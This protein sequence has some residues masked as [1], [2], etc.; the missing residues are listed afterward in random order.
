MPEN[1]IPSPDPDEFHELIDT[2]AR[3][4]LEGIVKEDDSPDV[5]RFWDDAA[6][7]AFEGGFRCGLL[8]MLDLFVYRLA[9]PG[10]PDP[11]WDA[12]EIG[13]WI[14]R[15]VI[16]LLALRQRQEVEASIRRIF[17]DEDGDDA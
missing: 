16:E 1:P 8:V 15:E 4:V 7:L 9:R 12:E 11:T 5:E 2:T 6:R 14:D 10:V 13:D 17:R 3:L